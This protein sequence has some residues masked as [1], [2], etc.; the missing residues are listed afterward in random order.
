MGAPVGRWAGWNGGGL[1]A[2]PW[3]WLVG[4]FKALGRLPGMAGCWPVVRWRLAGLPVGGNSGLKRRLGR[5]VPVALP[6]ERLPG[7]RVSPTAGGVTQ[8]VVP[9]WV[10]AIASRGF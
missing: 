8:R 7:R 3:W 4:G 10:L 6:E 1:A 5:A 9:D 2:P